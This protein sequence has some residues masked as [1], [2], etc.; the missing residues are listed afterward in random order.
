MVGAVR[1]AR[2]AGSV[3]LRP[4][5]YGFA[6]LTAREKNFSNNGQ[7]ILRVTIQSFLLKI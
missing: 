1:G 4:M 7:I 6:S 5:A 3:A 2:Y